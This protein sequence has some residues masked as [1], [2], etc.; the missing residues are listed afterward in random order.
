[1][2]VLAFTNVNKHTTKIAA[3]RVFAQAQSR[4]F[5]GDSQWRNSETWKGADLKV[6]DNYCLVT[7]DLS[8][9]DVGDVRVADFPH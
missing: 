4:V 7:R 6:G 5:P 1:M 9:A 3:V 2:L 8:A